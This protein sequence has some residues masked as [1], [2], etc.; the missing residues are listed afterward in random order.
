MAGGRGSRMKLP[1]EKPMLEINGKRLIEYVL[2]VL[3]GARH[4]DRI[5]I[6]ASS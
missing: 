3:A 6:A 5:Y 2:D 4:V 1:I